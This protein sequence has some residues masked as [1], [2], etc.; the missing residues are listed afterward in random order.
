MPN[1]PVYQ[2]TSF[3]ARAA[4]AVIG[5]ITGLGPLIVFVGAPRAPGRSPDRFAR[6]LRAP[7]RFLGRLPRRGPGGCSQGRGCRTLSRH[8]VR[9]LIC[10]AAPEP[11]QD[12]QPSSASCWAHCSIVSPVSGCQ[13]LRV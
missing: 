4:H 9:E 10:T 1:R 12:S 5:T 3:L 7:G 13:S 8:T 2:G 11:P 6:G